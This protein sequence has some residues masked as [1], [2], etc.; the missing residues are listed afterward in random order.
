MRPRT[1]S[2]LLDNEALLLSFK[3]IA[4]LQPIEL[5]VPGSAET[6]Y[7]TGGELAAEMGMRRLAQRLEGLAATTG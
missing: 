6:N 1:A 5:P 7:A 4:T 3:E 2:A